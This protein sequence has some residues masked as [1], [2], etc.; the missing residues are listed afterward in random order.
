[1]RQSEKLGTLVSL[2]NR[3]Q[4]A[5]R[6][7]EVESEAQRLLNLGFLSWEDVRGLYQAENSNG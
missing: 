3:L 7:K 2:F 1:M 4:G 6:L 5:E